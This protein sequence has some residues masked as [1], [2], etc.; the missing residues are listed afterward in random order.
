MSLLDLL[1]GRKH[2]PMIGLDISSSSAKL[3][4]LGM[5]ATGEY[6]LER[7]AS[8]IVACRVVIGVEQKHQH[9]GRPYSVR[10]DL[11]VPGHELVVNK[12]QNEDVYVAM[13]DAFDSM[14]RQLENLVER[15]RGEE[16]THP[17]PLH[18]EI[19]RIDGA[20]G[21]GFIRTPD[22]SEYYFSRDN[23]VSTPF[24]HMRTGAAVQFVPDTAGEGRQAK[25]VSL[26]KHAMG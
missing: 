2:V 20:S 10:V 19:V 5:S 4:E 16:K 6:V 18:G 24:E 7:L 17:V 8:D 21:F 9:Q 15:R 26:G 1:L 23:I 13:R 11:S 12:V 3:V 14:R 25:R 22:G